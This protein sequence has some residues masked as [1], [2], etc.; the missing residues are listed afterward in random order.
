MSQGPPE[1]LPPNPYSVEVQ[2]AELVSVA[3]QS[4]DQ[5]SW[6]IP[7]KNPAALIAYYLGLF[8]F[9]P[10]I[11]LLLAIPAVV[12]GIMGLRARK[13]NPEV[14]G[15]IHAWIGIAVGGLFAVIWGLAFVLI[16]VGI[17]TA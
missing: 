5:A 2:D 1:S 17:A 15:S 6:V 12:L 8:S 4:A 14:K 3:G 7:Y 9:I 16:V 13:R 10:L 11:G